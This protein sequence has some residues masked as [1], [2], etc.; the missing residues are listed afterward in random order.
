MKTLARVAMLTACALLALPAAAQDSA[1][2]ARAVTIV[3]PF[4]AGG[5]SDAIARFI[6]PVLA[7]KWGKPVLVDNRAGG[8]TIIAA[9]HVLSMP[10]DG[11]TIFYASYAWVTNQILNPNLPYAPGAMSPVTLLG[12][13]PLLLFI[14]AD[15]PVN[16][17]PELIAYAKKSQH[18]LNFGNAGTGS[19][20][21][22]TAAGFANAA[23]IEV[24]HVPYKGSAPA[25]QDVAGGQVD[26]AFE[27]LTYRQFVDGK[28]MKA[29][30]VAQPDALPDWPGLPTAK[31]AGLGSFNMA[32]WFG[33]LVPAKTPSAVQEKISADVAAAI[34]DPEVDAQLRK[35]GLIPQATKPGEFAAFL[36]AERVKLK[37]VIEKNRIK[38]E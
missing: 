36:E 33:L 17:V 27:G 23:G 13:Y 25:M 29:L 4:S 30:F 11:H 1:F 32:A 2:P 38:A 24:T 31:G 14:R 20:M 37:A 26:A 16:S 6:A 21:H 34:R 22:L 18:P 28:R 15:L 19:S 7:K 9:A 35:V 5:S 12:R 3:V 8:N 10:P